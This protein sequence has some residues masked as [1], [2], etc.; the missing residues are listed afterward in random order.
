[1]KCKICASELKETLERVVTCTYEK[2][3]P[4]NGLDEDDDPDN[5][6]LLL[7]LD[8]ANMEEEEVPDGIEVVTYE[9]YK[10]GAGYSEEQVREIFK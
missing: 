7:N 10:C 3:I 6:Y 5:G 9:C 1:M 4:I 8:Y 2:G